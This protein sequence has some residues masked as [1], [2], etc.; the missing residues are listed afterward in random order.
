MTR[1]DAFHIILLTTDVSLMK[2]IQQFHFR[3]VSL[4]IKI[5]IKYYQLEVEVDFRNESSLPTTVKVDRL[6]FVKLSRQL[7]MKRTE[8]IYLFTSFFRAFGITQKKTCHQMQP[9][10]TARQPL[11]LRRVFFPRKTTPYGNT[12]GRLE[13]L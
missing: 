1:N 13:D 4:H 5:L 6:N 9:S 12:E 2:Y 3:R 7:K 11:N 8:N 10:P